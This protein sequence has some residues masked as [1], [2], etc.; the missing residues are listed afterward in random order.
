MTAMLLAGLIT[1]ERHGPIKIGIDSLALLGIY[2]GAIA[3]QVMQ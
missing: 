2:A 1:R 3:I